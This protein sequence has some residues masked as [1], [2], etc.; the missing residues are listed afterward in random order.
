MR[1]AHNFQRILP[2]LGCLAAL[3]S[4]SVAYKAVEMNGVRIL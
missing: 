4:T 1:Y 2:I 3:A